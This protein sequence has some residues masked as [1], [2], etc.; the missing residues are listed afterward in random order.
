MADDKLTPDELPFFETFDGLIVGRDKRYGRFDFD[1][2]ALVD[3]QDAVNTIGGALGT[4]PSGYAEQFTLATAS[5]TLFACPAYPTSQ[6][7]TVEVFING[8]KV[9]FG[10]TGWFVPAAF[11]GVEA[12]TQVQLAFGVAAGTEVDIRVMPF[13]RAEIPAL[14]G[15]L[16]MNGFRITELIAP[17]TRELTVGSGGNYSTVN[18]AILGALEWLP[19]GAVTIRLL[20]GFVMNEQVIVSNQDLSFITIVSNASVVTVNPAGITAT[21]AVIDDARPVFG[22][23]GIGSVLP[24]IGALFAYAMQARYSGI[25]RRARYMQ[26]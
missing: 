22:A 25:Q 5:Q 24:R 2:A 23:T 20:A 11:V 26:Y 13:T 15:N 6:P 17:S 8:G 10:P 21:I 3:V 18:A 9:R 12:A 7:T 1:A 4:L 19:V 16:E 14:F